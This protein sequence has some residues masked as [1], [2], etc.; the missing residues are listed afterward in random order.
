MALEPQDSAESVP[1]G[2]V[3][4]EVNAD[5][6]REQ[7]DKVRLTAEFAELRPQYQR[8][9]VH[10]IATGS[11]E[12]AALK[13]GYSPRSAD[14]QGRRL[15]RN[16]RIRA[17][18]LASTQVAA[19]AAGVTADSHMAMLGTIRD[20]ARKA[21]QYGPAGR[22]EELIGKVVGLYIDRQEVSLVDKTSDAELAKQVASIVGISEKD[23]LAQLN[24]SGMFN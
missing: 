6:A 1:A 10:F 3:Q 22:C 16:V 13:A 15:W 20:E 24:K 21:S 19:K 23:A 8:W 14:K 11:P 9:V 4:T 12:D 5:L 7:L 17:A 2:V 18:L